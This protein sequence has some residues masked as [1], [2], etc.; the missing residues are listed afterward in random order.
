MLPLFKAL[1]IDDDPT[2]TFTLTSLLTDYGM[3]NIESCHT[4][5]EAHDRI[6]HEKWPIIF[7]DL[8]MDEGCNIE[9]ISKILAE[10]DSCY[11]VVITVENDISL[12]T[13]AIQLGA[14][15][16]IKKPI[17][18]EK[19]YHALQYILDGMY[20]EPSSGS[21]APSAMELPK[22]A[23]SIVGHDP[24]VTHLLHKAQQMALSPYPVLI[25]GES[26]SGKELFAKY[27]HQCSKRKGPIVTINAA[28]L[29]DEHFSDALFGHA[30][31]AFTG[32]KDGR[33]GLIQQA[34]QGTLVLD[35]IGS[36][37]TASQVKLL[38]LIQNNEYYALGSDQVQTSSA[39]L[40][41]CTNANLLD[42][43]ERIEFRHDLYYRLQSHHLHIPPLRLRSKS[44]EELIYHFIAKTCRDLDRSIVLPSPTYLNQLK[45]YD[46]PGNVR[47]LEN[48]IRQDILL[49]SG[50]H[51]DSTSLTAEQQKNN[52]QVPQ[53]NSFCPAN[54]TLKDM[55]IL[56]FFRE[57]HEDQ[58]LP[59]RDVTDGYIEEVMRKMG[60]VQVRAAKI[61]GISS[62]ALSQR[63][64]KR[65][66]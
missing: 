58:L 6:E 57:C 1:I 21:N 23:K 65:K 18:P 16:F 56:D 28:S 14:F 59:L 60:N 49:C 53:T 64:L 27:I 47:E 63:M 5:K 39:R 37:S 34:S 42:L 25:Q 24:L 32:I 17:V 44:L 7:L 15:D 13:R 22:E 41:F 36:L 29:D 43:C 4:M 9:F 8:M 31:H 62:Q 52:K 48:L 3:A 61:L 55:G 33:P 2:V 46:Y 40:I 19:L 20:E 51:L 12:T 45:S 26:G 38:R 10:Q 30:R 66:R 35:E 50:K 11:I 54:E